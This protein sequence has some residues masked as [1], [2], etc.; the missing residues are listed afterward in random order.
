MNVLVM[1]SYISDKINEIE[2]RHNQ[3]GL[4]AVMKLGEVPR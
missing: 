1:D 3:P 2:M 4:N